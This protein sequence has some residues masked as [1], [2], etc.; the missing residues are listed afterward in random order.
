M[1]FP[2]ILLILLYHYGMLYVRIK[3]RRQGKYKRCRQ[4][5]SVSRMDGDEKFIKIV[6]SACFSWESAPAANSEQSA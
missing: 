5:K 2:G 3:S 4:L 1:K 6:C